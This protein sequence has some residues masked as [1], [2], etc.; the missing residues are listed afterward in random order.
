MRFEE[1]CVFHLLKYSVMYSWFL[2]HTCFVLSLELLLLKCL[3]FLT[4]S[5]NSLPFWSYY[6]SFFSLLPI[7]VPQ[8]RLLTL[9]NTFCFCCLVFSSQDGYLSSDFFPWFSFL[10]YKILFL[11]HRC[12]VFSHLSKAFDVKVGLEVFLYIFCFS[13]LF[14]FSVCLC[15]SVSSVASSDFCSVGCLLV[16]HS[17]EMKMYLEALNMWMELVSLSIKSDRREPPLFFF[18]FGNYCSQ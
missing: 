12:N 9:S 1:R 11:F 10:F 2:P 4:G 18:F 8:P 5:L 7:R 6:P 16:F 14:S 3:I 15:E 17:R 13:K